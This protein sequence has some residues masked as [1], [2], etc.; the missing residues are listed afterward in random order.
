VSDP[1]D[2]LPVGVMTLSDDMRVRTANRY[3][4]ELVGRSPADL[5]G[6]S[7]D[8]LLSAP[9]RI[10]FQTH[11][12]PALKADGRVEEILLALD[13][14]AA[15]PTPVLFSAARSP[16]EPASYHAVFVRIMARARWESELLATTRALEQERAASQRLADELASAMRDIAA[17]HEDEQRMRQFR[18]AFVG[19]LSHELRTPITTI[20]GMSH[21]LRARHRTMGAE[22]LEAHLADIE[23]EADRLQ[24]LA[25]D[26]L[27]MSRAESGRLMLASEPT[28]V[29]RTVARAVAA[30]R[31][32]NPAREYRLSIDDVVPLVDGEDTYVEQVTRNYLSNAAKYSPAG[33]PIDVS[34]TYEDDGVAVRVVDYGAGFGTQPPEQ[35]FELFYRT[36][37]AVRQSAGAGIGLF[38]CRELVTAMGGRVWARPAAVGAEFGFWLPALDESAI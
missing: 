18:D 6:Q 4:A 26:L 5:A 36:P 34:V 12:F 17:R 38:V 8:V 7:I 29:S 14:G 15:E 3:L 2:A 20:F 22:R 33:T 27:V 1:L 16:D 21:L 24:R 31:S 9:T 23:L 10:L 11:V 30:E 19:V 25:E 13:A 37:E 28:A 32:R 35:L